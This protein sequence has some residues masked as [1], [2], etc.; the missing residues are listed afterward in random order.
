MKVSGGLTAGRGTFNYNHK[1]TH[2]DELNNKLPTNNKVKSNGKHKLQRF[3]LRRPDS[4]QVGTKVSKNHPNYPNVKKDQNK[5]S[6]T[7]KRTA[8]I[9][10]IHFNTQGLVGEER[11]NELEHALSKVE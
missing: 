10:L 6:K 9:K 8:S 4:S 1:I 3:E 5:E 2:S 7:Y 11:L